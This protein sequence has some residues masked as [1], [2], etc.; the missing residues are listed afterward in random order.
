MLVLQCA[1]SRCALSPIPGVVHLPS[2]L[3]LPQRSYVHARRKV[4]IGDSITTPRVVVRD[5]G[6]E[7]KADTFVMSASDAGI[8]IT[9]KELLVMT[10]NSTDR[11]FFYSFLRI[12]RHSR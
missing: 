3:S 9:A 1:V 12:R 4:K 7:L 5:P 2:H 10:R 6:T 8:R 11:L